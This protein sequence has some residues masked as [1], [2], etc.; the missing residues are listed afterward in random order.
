MEGRDENTSATATSEAVYSN[1]MA[2]SS[3]FTIMSGMIRTGR[4]ASR[5]CGAVSCSLGAEVRNGQAHLE[6][7]VCK[8]LKKKY[9]QSC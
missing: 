6:A 3:K 8:Y 2:G 1:W 7:R 5:R 4:T 9:S